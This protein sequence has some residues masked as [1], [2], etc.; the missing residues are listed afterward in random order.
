MKNF[1]KILLI[2]V[3]AF[4]L[5]SLTNAQNDNNK[6]H[7]SWSQFEKINNEKDFDHE[8]FM[9]DIYNKVDKED[10]RTF[11]NN[12]ELNQ[13][14]KALRDDY[15]AKVEALRKQYVIDLKNLVGDY[16]HDSDD[17]ASSTNS[18]TTNAT[19]TRV[20]KWSENSKGLHLG[21]WKKV[22]NWLGF[23]H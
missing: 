10:L 21:F 15:K 12:Q 18:S 6:N 13:K 19:N 1:K 3:C 5:I 20:T 8:D 22:K 4:L 17:N 16:R 23:N 9:E 14:V 7:P 2:P 11:T